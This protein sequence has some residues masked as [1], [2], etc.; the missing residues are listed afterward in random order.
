MKLRNA[1]MSIQRRGGNRWKLL[2]IA[3]IIAIA[4]LFWLEWL[5]SERSQRLTEIPVATP[6]TK[7]KTGSKI[8]R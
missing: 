7:E 4:L 5:G 2:V 1:P 8:D 6:D 3:A